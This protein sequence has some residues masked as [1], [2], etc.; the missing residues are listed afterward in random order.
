MKPKL[1]PLAQ[2]KSDPSDET[3][4]IQQDEPRRGV[5]HRLQ[6]R[7]ELALQIKLVGAVTLISLVGAI[8]GDPHLD[9]S[10]IADLE[11]ARAGL[12]PFD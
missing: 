8:F 6:D 1:Q 2:N 12:I 4:Q 11:G 7:A 9:G 3:K 5:S 10:L